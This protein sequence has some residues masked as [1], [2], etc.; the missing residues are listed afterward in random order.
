[1][2]LKLTAIKTQQ[3]SD[4]RVS[5]FMDDAYFCSL[6]MLQ[7]VELRLHVGQEFT[8]EEAARIQHEG[9]FSKAYNRVLNFLA[10][11]PRSTR[12][13]REYLFKKKYD[14]QIQTR[15]LGRIT[16]KGY[17]NDA[18]FAASWVRSRAATK[19]VSRR[20]LQAELAGKGVKGESQQQAMEGYDERAAL[21]KIIDKKRHHS[22]YQDRQKFIA[23]LA[24]QGFPYDL[25]QELLG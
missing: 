17:V 22:R 23:Y 14:E 25:I 24:R 18:A 3:K 13:V 20:R 11:R 9:E 6:D 15:I 12:E 2:T 16:E 7:L 19:P 5:L 8:E 4:S 21:Q 10:I 1:L